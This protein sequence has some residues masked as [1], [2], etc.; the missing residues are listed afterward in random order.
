MKLC[1]LKATPDELNSCVALALNAEDCGRYWLFKNCI[2]LGKY[3]AI[4]KEDWLPCTDWS[5]G[6][7][8]IEREK[9]SLHRFIDSTMYERWE[10]ETF[11]NEHY[12][13]CRQGDNVQGSTAL[14]AAMRAFVLG[15]LGPVVE[16]ADETK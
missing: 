3:S 9:I 7:P 10:A 5:L 13:D 16:L 4:F 6:G 12:A 11:K 2:T 14:I 8:I 15:K 1:P